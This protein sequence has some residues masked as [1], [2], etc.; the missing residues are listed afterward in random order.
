MIDFRYQI[1]DSD[2]AA[3]L[4]NDK[5]NKTYLVDLATGAVLTIPDLA[6]IGAMRTSTKNLV[7]GKDYFIMFGNPG[8]F[9]KHGSNVTLVIG[10]L[11]IEHLTIE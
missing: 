10:D 2:K 6:K 9:L 1:T 11:R 7:R 4:F 5:K 8:M 3:F